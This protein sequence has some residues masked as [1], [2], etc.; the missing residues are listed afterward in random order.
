MHPR[1]SELPLF[2]QEQV[3]KHGYGIYEI[4]FHMP[5]VGMNT[6]HLVAAKNKADAI[7]YAKVIAKANNYKAASITAKK[8][9]ANGKPFARSRFAQESRQLVA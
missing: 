8:L 3:L 2:E 9:E 1:L 4:E 7:K 6:Y 5:D